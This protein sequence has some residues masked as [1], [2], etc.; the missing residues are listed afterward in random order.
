M[1]YY[2]QEMHPSCLNWQEWVSELN[3]NMRQM[4]QEQVPELAGII[5]T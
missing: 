1:I 5:N 3:K 2:T 4:A